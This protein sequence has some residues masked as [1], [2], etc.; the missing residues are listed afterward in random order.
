MGKTYD[1]LFDEAAKESPNA[2]ALVYQLLQGEE[3]SYR[4][5][6][7]QEKVEKLVERFVTQEITE[8][9]WV[10]VYLERSPM[11]VI[12][13]LA[14]SK[15]KAIYVPL[16]CERSIDD[17]RAIIDESKLHVILMPKN[18]FHELHKS[19]SKLKKIEAL[20]PASLNQMAI[21]SK[22][23]RDEQKSEE[24]KEEEGERFSHNN[25][26]ILHTLRWEQQ[27]SDKKIKFNKTIFY[28]LYSSGT[29]GNPKGIPIGHA[30]LE[31]WYNELKNELKGERKILANI[32][33][34]FDAHIW[35]DLMAWATRGCLC[36]INQ[37]Q[38]SNISKMATWA[39][40]KQITDI[41]MMPFNQICYSVT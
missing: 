7:L 35:E 17:L 18:N 33:V 1:Q 22:E 6:E 9:T 4:Y 25:E 37:E 19:E 21:L 16:D 3:V 24:Y 36:L 15:I 39:L 11:Q 38:Y 27:K 2:T 40:K 41:T 29:T 14:L 8:G 5:S 32:T 30:G 12:M 31:R 20:L 28:I 34:G 10:G 23:L 13:R 26:Y